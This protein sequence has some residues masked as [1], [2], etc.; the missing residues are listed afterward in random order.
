MLDRRGLEA[1]QT[2]VQHHN[3]HVHEMLTM[4]PAGKK[5]FAA[6]LLEPPV[7]LRLWP[8]HDGNHLFGQFEWSSFE[9]HATGH[10]IETETKVDVQDV[11][12]VIDHDVAI[13]SILELQKPR[14]YR[15][16]RHAFDEVV[17]GLLETD[18][19]F[20][21]V[22]GDE[23]VVEAVDGFATE[24]VARDGIWKDIDDA[25]TGCCCRDTIWVNVD[26]KPD[27]VEYA[28]ECGDHLQSEDVLSAVISDLENSGLPDFDRSFPF[29]LA[30]RVIQLLRVF[31]RVH[32]LLSD[33]EGS[34]EWGF[35]MT[36][37]WFAR[38]SIYANYGPI[39]IARQ[40]NSDVNL[41]LTEFFFD[42]LLLFW[43][44]PL[45]VW[46]QFARNAGDLIEERKFTF[47]EVFIFP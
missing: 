32:L 5:G 39:W 8:A 24:H 23:I 19:V 17:A 22:F 43:L 4:L 11:T 13:V 47:V 12:C 14:D 30:K 29:Q 27:V 26:V 40:I 15:I 42:L 6:E 45:D 41:D 10:N 21:A 44:T 34:H 7:G 36:L 1:W 33:T 46:F 16:S 9:L 2:T 18:R 31:V 20:A 35:G 25:A 28:T 38:L 3:H 37:Q